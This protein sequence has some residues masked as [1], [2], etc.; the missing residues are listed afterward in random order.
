MVPL[1]NR[2]GKTWHEKRFYSSSVTEV[3][4]AH[5]FRKR[6]TD[7]GS[8]R[9]TGDLGLGLVVD[10]ASESASATTLKS[11]TPNQRRR[12]VYPDGSVNATGRRKTAVAVVR[13][14][15]VEARS[16]DTQSSELRQ[17]QMGPRFRVNGQNMADYFHRVDHRLEIM[18]PFMVTG[19]EKKFHVHAFVRGGGITGQAEALR[20]SIA[21]ALEDFDRK[22]RSELKPAGLLT[23][24]PR[25]V[26]RKKYGRHKAR[27]AFQWVKR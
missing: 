26:E 7:T 4:E 11:Q 3:T 8:N 16:K 21:R 15:P 19:T 27:R 2:K 9:G 1:T 24:D 17:M 18:R 5:P 20:L 13:I 25:M 22:F 23:R 14:F 6:E 12:R 10:T